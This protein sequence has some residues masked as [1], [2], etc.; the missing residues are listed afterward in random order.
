M[1]EIVG[2]DCHAHVFARTLRLAA[3][4]RYEPSGEATLADFFAMLAANGMTH[5]VLVQPSFLGNDNNYLLRALRSSPDRLRGIAVVGPGA[6]DQVLEEL[7]V[8]GCAGVRLNLIGQPD[9]DF[10]KPQWTRHLRRVAGRG[11]QIELHAEAARLSLILPPLLD[12]GAPIVIDHFG[13]PNPSAGIDDPGFQFLLA[14]GATGRIWV[15]LS[16]AYRLGKGGAGWRTAQQAVPMLRDAF[17]LD[18]LIWGS[19]WPH[20]Q[21]EHVASPRET[22]RRLDEWLPNTAERAVVLRDAPAR[23]FG[24]PT[25]TF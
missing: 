8:A 20:T 18:R 5:G 17:G 10:S 16:A 6:S 15:K 1:P 9:P 3:E 2:I 22:R 23:L 12:T 11:W 25:E 19:D 4:R 7:H 14:H 21:F 24:F 13:R